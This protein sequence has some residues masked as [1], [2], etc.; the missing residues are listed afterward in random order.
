MDKGPPAKKVAPTPN[1][2]VGQPPPLSGMPAGVMPGMAGVG[3]AP[4]TSAGGQYREQLAQFWRMQAQEIERVSG[5]GMDM[6][7]M[8]FNARKHAPP[9]DRTRTRC[10]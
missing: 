8:P 4:N 10:T 6:L 5:D 9:R 7:S 3:M 1:H 2:G